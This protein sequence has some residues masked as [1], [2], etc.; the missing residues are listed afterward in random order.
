MWKKVWKDLYDDLIAMTANAFAED[1]KKV[2]EMGMNGHIAKPIDVAKIKE[3]V[4]SVLR[5]TLQLM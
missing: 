4:A 5:L 1:R 2:F 3:A